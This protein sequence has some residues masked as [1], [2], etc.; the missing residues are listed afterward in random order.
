[1]KQRL[2]IDGI[3]LTVLSI[4]TILLYFFP[5]LFVGQLVIDAPLNFLGLL[6]IQKGMFIRMSARGHKRAISPKGWGLAKTGFYA[7]SRN[8][9]YL[10][11]F[12]SGVGFALI[13]WPWWALPIFAFLFYLRFSPT[14]RL[15][16]AH[17]KNMF[18]K[19]YEDYCREVPQIFPSLSKIIKIQKKT[20]C[21]WEELWTTKEKNS[22]WILPVVAFILKVVSDKILYNHWDIKEKLF[23]LTVGV[24]IFWIHLL[25]EYKIKHGKNT[26]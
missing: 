24:C 16:E 5:K 8:P 6:L 21:P 4:I 14:I 26:K 11:S 17:L 22:I 23:I 19:E 2:K 1:M 9:M 25:Y 20:E 3:I 18:G 13:L 7:Y 10:G 15:E 12:L